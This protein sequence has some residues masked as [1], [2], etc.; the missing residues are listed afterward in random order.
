MAWRKSTDRNL[1]KGKTEV[2]MFGTRARLN[3]QE[4]EINIEYNSQQINVSDS[5]KYIGVV[6]DQTLSLGPHFDMVSKKIATRI[7]LLQKIKLL[8]T[9]MAIL[10]IYQAFTLPLVTYC[11]LTNF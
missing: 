11:S 8:L 5:Y 4:R 3:K 1:K 6:L 9:E 7:R 10:N 2:T